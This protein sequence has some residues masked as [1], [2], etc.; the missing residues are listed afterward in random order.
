MEE[1]LSCQK[2]NWK[3]AMEDKFQPLQ[4]NQEMIAVNLTEEL[5]T[6]QF[7]WFREMVGHKNIIQSEKEC[8]GWTLSIM[9]SCT[10]VCVVYELFTLDF[11]V[12]ISMHSVNPFWN[13]LEL[14]NLLVIVLTNFYCF[15]NA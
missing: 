15:C 13:I 2:K 9:L 12:C 3:E 5:H 4:A 11:C 10:L 1:P 8:Q 6:E 7:T 14:R